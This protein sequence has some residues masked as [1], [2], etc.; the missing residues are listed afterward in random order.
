MAAALRPL[1]LPGFPNLSAAYLVNELGNWLGEIALA[2]LVY[3][4]TGSPMATAALFCGMHFAPA[5]LGPPLVARVE[6]L[7]VSLSLPL[8]YAA[9]AVAFGL[10][11]VLVDQFALAFVLIL[12]TFDGSIAS[13]ARALTRAAAAAILTP[14]GQLRE[15]N[16]L[17]NIAFTVGS[18]GGPALAGLV[19][20][21][22]GIQAAL[23]ADALSFLAVAGVLA[24]APLKAPEPDE[25]GIPW[26]ERLRRGIAYVRGHRALG[27]LLVAQ[28]FA[29]IFFALVIPIEVVFAV[30]T[31]NAGDAG[32][33]ILLASWGVG[34]LVG[35]LLFAALSK[36]ELRLLLVVSTLAIGAAYLGTSVAPTLAVACVASVIGG[37]G[38]GV[39]WI[40]LVTTV[41]ELT[42][43]AY[44]A[45]ILSLLEAT[46]SAMPGVGFLLGGAIA[47]I[48]SPRL[49]YAVAGAGVVVVLVFAAGALRGIDWKSELAEGSDPDE[50]A[51]ASDAATDAISI[52]EEGASR[53]VLTSS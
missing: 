41:Q 32:Y 51:A 52:A 20:A 48:F 45:R 31:L 12:A 1:R 28:A 40:A 18:A 11:A 34:M 22:A 21:G 6:T 25:P 36:V 42:R 26:G 35:S 29:F 44:Q 23:I 47:A 37:I 24:V 53:S 50:D 39:Q 5:F 9:E 13:A 46:A 3:K 4:Q 43:A 14:A 17:L 27:S 33:G 7:P 16:A 15:G 10:L 19:V 30:D 2:I 38:N 8:L 49:S